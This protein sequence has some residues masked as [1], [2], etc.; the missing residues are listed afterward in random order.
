MDSDII[1]GDLITDHLGMAST[2]HSI[3]RITVSMTHSTDRITVTVMGMDMVDMAIV[4]IIMEDTLH[5]TAITMTVTITVQESMLPVDLL[6]LKVLKTEPCKP[7][8]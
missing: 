2:I 4:R 6:L 5:I 3:D 1:H 8:V 7:E